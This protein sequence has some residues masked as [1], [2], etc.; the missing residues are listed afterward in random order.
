MVK[1]LGEKTE[2]FTIENGSTAVLAAL[3]QAL[4]GHPVSLAFK[5]T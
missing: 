5:P 3:E 4:V 2:L 1:W